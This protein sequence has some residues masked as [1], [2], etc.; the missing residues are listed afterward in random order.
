LEVS[1]FLILR[2]TS[3]GMPC[4]RHSPFVQWDLHRVQE[5]LESRDC[6]PALT[7]MSETHDLNDF[8]CSALARGDATPLEGHAVLSADWGVV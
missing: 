2:E 7:P 5:W 3:R 6:L 8:V 4:L 1:P